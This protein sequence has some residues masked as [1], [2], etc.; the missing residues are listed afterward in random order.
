[1]IDVAEV[2]NTSAAS[3]PIALDRAWRAGRIREG[4]LVLFTSFG[5]GL[6][7][8]ATSFAGRCRSRAHD[9]TPCRGRHRGVARASG[10]R[11]RS[12]SRRRAGSVAVGY[13][14][15]EADAK[16]AVAALEAAGTPGIAVFLDTTDEAGVH[17]AFRRVTDELGNVTGLINNAGLSQDGLLLKYKHGDVRPRDGHERARGLPV[18]EVG[19]ARHAEGEVGPHGE[20]ELGGGAARQR[21]PDGLRRN[22]DGAGRASPSRSPARSARR[23]SP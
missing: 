16:E 14:S 20:H 4:D 21:R 17:E 8:G 7:W 11:A 15:N 10:A 6:T 1:M 18:L 2:G 13:R 3:I 22:E 23:A 9:R 5:A 19:V 12:R